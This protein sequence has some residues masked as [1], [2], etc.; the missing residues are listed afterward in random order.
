MDQA[1]LFLLVAKTLERSAEL[2]EEHVER[3]R[4]QGLWD[5]AE[6]ATAGR[7]RNAATHARELAGEF[8]ARHSAR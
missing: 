1:E 2:A 5:P 3:D 6:V 4:R 8:A 7:A